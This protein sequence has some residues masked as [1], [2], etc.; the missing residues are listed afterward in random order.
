[1]RLDNVLPPMALVLAGLLTG[2]EAGTLVAT[3]PTLSRLGMPASLL[4][5]QS[6]TRR[7]GALMPPLMAATVAVTV[8]T[9]GVTSG[10]RRRL[11]AAAGASYAAM[12]GITLVGNV[13]LNAATLRLAADA[14]EQE[15]RAVRRRWD[16]LHALRV[17][18]DVTGLA[19]AAVAASG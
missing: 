11:F 8:V 1:M 13:P 3:H 14:P 17:A 6:L 18:L 7:Y 12:L 10:A 5:E 2:N 9:A 16:R 19:L 15:L 4:A